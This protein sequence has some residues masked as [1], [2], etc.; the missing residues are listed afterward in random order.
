MLDFCDGLFG[1]EHRIHIHCMNMYLPSYI[2]HVCYADISWDPV[3]DG[4]GVSPDGS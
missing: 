2:P 1:L 3:L 4:I